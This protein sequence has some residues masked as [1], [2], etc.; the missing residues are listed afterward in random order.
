MQLAGLH[1]FAIVLAAVVSFMFGWLWYG[2]LFPKQWMKAA[3]KT[4]ADVK[5]DGGPS[6]VPFVISFIALL[7][8]AW[9]LGGIIHHLGPGEVTLR[10]GAATGALLWLGFVATTLVVNHTF[11]GAKPA[12]TVLDAGHWLGVLLLQGAVIGWLGG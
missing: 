8:M 12:L 7:V 2:V 5:S 10:H 9:V 3:G 11:Q 4:E 1:L 6:P